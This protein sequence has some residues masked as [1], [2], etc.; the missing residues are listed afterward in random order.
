ML[1]KYFLTKLTTYVI[2]TVYVSHA[3]LG[4]LIVSIQITDQKYV[5]ETNDLL[6]SQTTVQAVL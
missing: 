3:S 1:N 4:E 6:C 5:I 2:K